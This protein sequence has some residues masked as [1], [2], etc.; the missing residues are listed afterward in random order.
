MSCVL[1]FEMD[2]TQIAG[3]VAGAKTGFDM[4][5][6]AIGLVRDVQG[7]LPEG[8]KKDVVGRTLAEADKQ[9]AL[10]EAQIAQALGYPLCRCQFPPI[11]M[12][13]VGWTSVPKPDPKRGGNRMVD[14]DAHECP[15]CLQTDVQGYG[16]ERKIPQHEEIGNVA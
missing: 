1:D 8:E 12:L 4:L 6:A 7:V 15:K 9:V 11:P 3:A 2:L 16:I 5:R 10:A 13:K 14:V